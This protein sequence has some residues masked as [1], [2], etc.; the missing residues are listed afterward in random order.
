MVRMVPVCPFEAMSFS[1]PGMYCGWLNR[2]RNCAWNSTDCRS[3]MLKRF[4]TDMSQLLMCGMARVLR[5][6][7]AIAPYDAVMFRSELRL[8]LNR[9][10]FGDVE[11][12]HH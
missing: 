6:E 10:P 3:V 1:N 9:L 5:G 4:T 12:L 7:L 11:A 8:E 2:F